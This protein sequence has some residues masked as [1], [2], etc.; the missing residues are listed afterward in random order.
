M[1]F[2]KHVFYFISTILFL[3]Y[4]KK[5]GMMLGDSYILRNRLI[6]HGLLYHKYVLFFYRVFV[7][8][9][10]VGG[11]VPSD[12]FNV[13]DLLATC[14]TSCDIYVFGYFLISQNVF[15]IQFNFKNEI[16]IYP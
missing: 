10:N 16:L 9:W 5:K 6:F 2:L 14:H 3:N 11:V 7:N 4:Q 8:T 12:D 15:L 1:K 13:D